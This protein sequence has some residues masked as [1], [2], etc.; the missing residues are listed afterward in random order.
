MLPFMVACNL[1]REDTGSEEE[2][3][4]VGLTTTQLT[5]AK[6]L[7]SKNTA[8]KVVENEK[9][10]EEGTDTLVQEEPKEK[11]ITKQLRPQE[12]LLESL[13]KGAKVEFAP[14]DMEVIQEDTTILS[15]DSTFEISYQTRCIN[16]SLIA[17]EMFDYGGTNA[18]SYRDFSQL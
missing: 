6:D 3:D 5:T 14:L 7:S 10:A 12:Q 2:E 8:Q 17:Q 1:D 9:F 15:N 11:I 13:T 4:V 16:D 18:K